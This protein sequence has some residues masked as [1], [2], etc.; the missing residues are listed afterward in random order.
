MHHI[1][2]PAI[3][4]HH[5]FLISS[6]LLYLIP[7][8][9]AAALPSLLLCPSAANSAAHLLCQ[10]VW[11]QREPGDSESAGQLPVWTISPGNARLKFLLG[12]RVRR[13]GR[14]GES[15][16]HAA[17]V[18][19]LLLTAGAGQSC[20]LAAGKPKGSQLQVSFAMTYANYWTLLFWSPPTHTASPSSSL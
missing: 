7:S 6:L 13:T 18:L 8:S 11:S 15:V 16:R 9:F 14:R 19:P 17:H 3:L 10:E 4:A 12:E 20:R 2:S 1:C 5:Y